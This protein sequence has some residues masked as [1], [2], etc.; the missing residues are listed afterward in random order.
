MFEIEDHAAVGDQLF[1]KLIGSLSVAMMN[2]PMGMIFF[3]S[4]FVTFPV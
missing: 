3:W 2:E 4:F 1:G